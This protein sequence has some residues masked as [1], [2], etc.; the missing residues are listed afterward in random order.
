MPVS[1]LSVNGIEVIL[2]IH[3][4]LVDTVSSEKLYGLIQ[5]QM[6]I[7]RACRDIAGHGMVVIEEL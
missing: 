7:A 4:Q 3:G 1:T 6:M 5:G 2:P